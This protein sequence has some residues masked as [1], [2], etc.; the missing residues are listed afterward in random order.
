MFSS[1]RELLVLTVLCTLLASGFHYEIENVHLFRVCQLFIVE[2][3]LE[4][5]SHFLPGLVNSR[6]AFL[7]ANKRILLCL[8]Y[9]IDDIQCK[10]QSDESAL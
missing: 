9:D 3:S 4:D 7:V 6:L 10:G 1:F 5:F 8:L 2:L